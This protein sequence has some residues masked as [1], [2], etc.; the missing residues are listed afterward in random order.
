[1]FQ[2]RTSIAF[3][4]VDILNQSD[5][6]SL[7]GMPSFNQTI[8]GVGL[9]RAEHRI[10]PAGAGSSRRARNEDGPTSDSHVGGSK[11]NKHNKHPW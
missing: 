3:R 9:P 1:M 11:I 6:V 5:A 8:R 2:L 10:P 7:I 4:S